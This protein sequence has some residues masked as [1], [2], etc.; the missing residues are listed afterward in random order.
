MD[1]RFIKWLNIYD[2]FSNGT[3]LRDILNDAIRCYRHGIARPALM[4]SYIAFIQ[5]VRNN[6]LNSEMPSGFKKARW[7][8][9][10]NN[11]RSEGNWD[12]E[13]VD[14]IKKRANGVSDPAFFELNDTLRND[15]CYW[16]SRRNDC[17]HYKDSE[18]TLSHVS[19]FWVFM[20]DNYNKFTPIGSLQQSI[21]DYNRHF[22]ISRTP[23]GASTDKIFKRLCLVIK[24]KEDLEHFL[25][26]TYARM[27]F[28][29][30]CD[31]LHNLLVDGLHKEIVICFLKQ[32]KKRLNAYLRTK[33]KDVSL[34]LGNDVT[35]TRR[36][37]Y[38]DF[39]LFANCKNVYVEMLRARMIPDNEIKESL[40]LLLKHEYE[41]GAFY[42]DDDAI[43]VLM[44]NGLY[45]IFIEE[46]L[47]KSF[48]CSY[49][50]QKCR[51]TDFYISLIAY[52][53]ITDKLILTLSDTV[54][55][56]FPY[57]LKDRL[58]DDIFSTEENKNKYLQ[59]IARLGLEVFLSLKVNENTEK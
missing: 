48:V 42:V 7:D 24:T 50:G 46:Y 25:K 52:G 27:N 22:D 39:L 20:M 26:E 23:R 57:S 6:L 37:W 45:D 29:S 41:R 56:T 18:I 55:G 59:T 4:L 14:C 54:K 53:G 40:E 33:P 12:S 28:E 30:Q 36:F 34:V 38:E 51:K 9:C 19:A 35:T 11:L 5:A 1:E 47:S 2:E 43:N 16:R 32:E 8:A 58:I 44:D 3:V 31:L 21:N 15:V 17:A 49:P 13:V 10:M